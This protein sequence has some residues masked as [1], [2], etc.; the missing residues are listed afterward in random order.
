MRYFIVAITLFFAALCWGEN[1]SVLPTLPTLSPSEERF[2]E[3]VV[4]GNN[5]LGFDVFRT[6]KNQ[7]G[8]LCFSPYSMASGLAIVAS[9]AKGETRGELQRLLHYSLSLLPLFGDLNNQF[10]DEAKTGSQILMANA[11][12]IEKDLP[13]LPSFKLTVQRDIQATLQFMDFAKDKG[14]SVQ[15]INQW[16]SH[17]TRG[18]INQLLNLQDVSAQTRLVLTAAITMKG[19]WA[20]PFDPKLTKRLPFQ[21]TPT[22]TFMANMMHATS[23]YSLWKGE[24]WD[25]LEIPYQSGK[26][27]GQLS[28]MLLLPK[29]A[30]LEELEDQLTWEN[31][32]QWMGKLQMQA[33]S[34]IMPQ[35]RIEKRFDLNPTLTSLG[36]SL[37][38]N[39]DADFSGMTGQ[40]GLFLNEAI[41]KTA[42]Q[43]DEKGMEVAAAAGSSFPPAVVAEAAQPY[44]FK[45]DHPFLFI[46]FDRKTS[47]ILFMG[48]L[49]LP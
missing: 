16:V 2:F 10:S 24:K 19:V 26:E 40:K 49:A 25:L 30:S 28:M 22:R 34:L 13:L 5:R 42:I 31:W 18:K 8:N 1:E 3:M 15:T 37:A 4:E 33:V 45:A 35:F 44:E 14:K 11:L 47:S 29:K 46:I 38:F 21:I 7:S 23:H 36:A 39:P 43:I 32:K 48:R 9:G 27:G 41:H 17:Q 20:R 12:W 6:I